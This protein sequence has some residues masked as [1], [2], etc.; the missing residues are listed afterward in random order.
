MPQSF[1][2]VSQ[3]YPMGST[4]LEDQRDLTL[5]LMAEAKAEAERREWDLDQCDTL[6]EIRDDRPEDDEAQ[7]VVT[8]RQRA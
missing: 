6:V 4:T 5:V 2:T 7:I 8:V 3:P 1:E